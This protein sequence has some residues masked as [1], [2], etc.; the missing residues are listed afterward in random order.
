MAGA[1]LVLLPCC[2]AYAVRRSAVLQVTLLGVDAAQV[3]NVEWTPYSGSC[4]LP[5]FS[6]PAPPQTRFV[7]AG[8]DSGVGVL[9]R[10]TLRACDVESVAVEL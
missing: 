7:V 1:W 9:R 10:A 6:H 8:L 4:Q 5:V 3:R 2:L